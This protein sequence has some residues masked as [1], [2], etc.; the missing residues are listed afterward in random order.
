M[1]D[2]Y[3]DGWS[4]TKKLQLTPGGA[5]EKHIMTAD[6]DFGFKEKS[7]TGQ[8]IDLIVKKPATISHDEHGTIV[9][10]PGK[11]SKTN[12]MEFDP[13]NNTVSYIFD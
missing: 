8:E 6:T 1:I 13:F 5:P 11:Y 12:Q 4:S 9:L 3:T 7:N 10:E 2:N